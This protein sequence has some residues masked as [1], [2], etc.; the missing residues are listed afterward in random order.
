MSFHPET[1]KRLLMGALVAA[2]W[3]GTVLFPANAMDRLT[4]SNVETIQIDGREWERSRPGIRTFDAV[5]RAVLI[6][7]PGASEAIWHVLQSGKTIERAELVLVYA[8]HE[9]R[10][11]GYTI[12]DRVSVPRWQEQAPRWHVVAQALRQPWIAHATFGPT[13]RYRIRLIAPWAGIGASDPA[14]DLWPQIL[15]PAELSRAV[16][17]ARLDLTGWLKQDEKLL[18]R[19]NDL[20][21]NGFRLKKLETHDMRYR[22][23]GEIYEW[24][25]ATGGHGIAFAEARLEV[26]FASRP[27]PIP[28]E[29]LPPKRDLLAEILALSPDAQV[30]IPDMP[31]IALLQ[32]L[33]RQIYLA[34]PAWM[35]PRQVEHL[36]DLFRAGGDHNTQ[37]LFD[38][39][40]QDL[41]SYRTFLRNSLAMLPRYWR[42]WDIIDSLLAVHQLGAF[43]PPHVRQHVDQYW[44]SYLLPDVQTS[45]LLVPHSHEASEDWRKTGDWRGRISF[46]RGYSRVGS[47]QNFNF[48]AVTGA[49]L[50]GH[51]I[52]AQRA[53]ED[54]RQ[55]LIALLLRHWT[56][57]DGGMQE[58][59]DPYYLSITLSAAKALADHAP[60]AFDRLAARIMVER[61]MEMLATAYHPMTKRVVAAAGRARL[62]GFLTEQDG[63]YGALHVL[64]EKGALLYPKRPRNARI[65]GLPIWGYD[66]PPG[67]IALQSLTG[68]WAPRWFQSVIDQKPFPFEERST[69]T[70]RGHFNPPLYRTSYLTRYFGL[71]SQDLKGGVADLLATWARTDQPASG[72]DQIGVLFPRACVNLCDLVTTSGGT[73]R[74]AGS[75]ATVQNQN[76]AIVFARPPNRADRLKKEQIGRDVI[77]T[78]GSILGFWMPA[79]SLTWRLFVNGEEKLAKDLPLDLKPDSIITLAD[80]PSFLGIRPIAATPFDGSET[81]RIRLALG[82]FGG[83]PEAS[84]ETI[85]PTLTLANMHVLN[86]PG[87]SLADYDAAKL[88]QKSYGGFVIE[89]ADRETIPNIAEF[90]DHMARNKLEVHQSGDRVSVR[91][92]AEARLLEAEFSLSVQEEDVHFPIQP[93]SQ[94]RAISRRVADGNV[95]ALPPGIDRDTSWSQQGRSGELEKQG[96]RLK[97]ETGRSAYLVVSP[98]RKGVL[99]YNLLPEETDFALTW[100]DGR[101]IRSEGKVSMLRIEVNDET[102]TVSINHQP[103]PDQRA[104]LTRGFLLKGFGDG[105]TVLDGEGNLFRR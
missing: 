44:A 75:L 68:P 50:G 46:F 28:L 54:G 32:R 35:S 93:G 14:Q 24:S 73:P 27:S 34:A 83:K 23:P 8:S 101:E 7:F 25:V 71:A 13:S 10:P 92:G 12:R 99:A 41:R 104:S 87:L 20:D 65:D 22:G 51:Q 16:P 82:G 2:A 105:W 102:R 60:S 49:L 15:G 61:T 66:A 97:T 76:R 91:Y 40:Y 62:S 9:T 94:T 19:L 18:Q 100:S 59:L 84:S 96:V 72:A 103:E 78:A 43:L 80:G 69:E 39:Q 29:T 17:S 30:K 31:D 52:G 67:R 56:V 90:N 86:G 36:S 42:G 89:M 85:E 53:I 5:H 4:F 38:L 88:G 74:K 95:I 21:T 47:T 81:T 77:D 33:A 57:Q 55:G 45:S 64:S 3:C 98:D 1:V 48:T 70:I 79:R 37:W 11:E 63:I 26:V 6:R 58:M